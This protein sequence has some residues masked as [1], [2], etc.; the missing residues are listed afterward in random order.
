MLTLSTASII[1]TSQSF[2][3]NH[4]NHKYKTKSFGIIS[5]QNV[6]QQIFSWT[7]ESKKL[8]FTDIK[9]IK[10]TS[11]TEKIKLNVNY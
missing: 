8:Q 5:Q 7:R 4:D 2:T 3:A 9:E 11:L 1:L 10:N 6:I